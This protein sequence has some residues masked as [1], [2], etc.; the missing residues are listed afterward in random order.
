MKQSLE[1]P[2]PEIGDS[3]VLVGPLLLSSMRLGGHIILDQPI[4][5]AEV[6]QAP[7]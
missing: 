3:P 1:C 2:L 5:S 4:R 7:E 6:P